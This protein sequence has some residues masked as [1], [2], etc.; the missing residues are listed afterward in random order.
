MSEIT[1]ID[2]NFDIKNEISD[3][4]VYYN[5]LNEPF[6]THGIFFE[7]GIYRRIP[8]AVAKATSPGVEGVHKH[9]SGGR[10]RYVTNSPKVAFR[11]KIHSAWK[12][13]NEAVSGSSGFDLYER[14]DGKIQFVKGL[15]PP[16]DAQGGYGAVVNFGTA[17]ER[18]LIFNFPQYAGVSEFEVGINEGATLKAPALYTVSTPIVFYGSSI[19]QG[20]CASRPG[21]S[22]ENIIS[23]EF[24]CDYINLGFSGNAKGERSIAEYIAGLNMSVFVYDYDFNAPTAEYLKETHE[25]MFKIIRDAHPDLPIIMMSRPSPAPNAERVAVIKETYENALKSG[26]KNVYFIHGQELTAISGHDT[27]VDNTHPNDLGFYSMAT[28]VIKVLKTIFNK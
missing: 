15:V 2:K 14:R 26:D 5:T 11:A 27:T 10:V 8:E 22:Y 25:P 17:E 19:T 3:E 21:L 4:L 7:G 1:K 13:N 20:A 16:Q 23:R 24:D 12:L 6:S 18:E 9:T 28:A